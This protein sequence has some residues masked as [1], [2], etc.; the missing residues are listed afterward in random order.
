MDFDNLTEEQ[1]E[2]V[3][4]CKTQEE[5]TALLAE[6]GLELADEALESLAGGLASKLPLGRCAMYG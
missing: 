5:L 4:A 6:E 2:R 1:Q 3:R